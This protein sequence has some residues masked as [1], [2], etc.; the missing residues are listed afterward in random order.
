MTEQD[1]PAPRESII[2]PES[3][4]QPGQTVH[5]HWHSAPATARYGCL[6]DGSAEVRA[7]RE[8]GRI[9]VREVGYGSY[10]QDVFDIRPESIRS[11][12]ACVQCAMTDQAQRAA[13]AWCR[14]QGISSPHRGSGGPGCWIAG[15][16]A[17]RPDADA[18]DLRV[19]ACGW[20][21]EFGPYFGTPARG[22]AHGWLS[23]RADSLHPAS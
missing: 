12:T 19:R 17:V 11:R 8:D 2:A 13:A 16:Q 3:T 6:H 7:I 23:A 1:Y 20:Q 15:Y 18:D 10:P 9:T 5:V 14:E 4:Y 21:R 22:F